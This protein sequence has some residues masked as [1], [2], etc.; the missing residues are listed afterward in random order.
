MNDTERQLRRRLA[1]AMLR[2]DALENELGQYRKSMADLSLMLEEDA[3][4]TAVN[5]LHRI[6]NPPKRIIRDEENF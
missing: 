5:E 6:A 1:A 4:Q 3:L 2:I